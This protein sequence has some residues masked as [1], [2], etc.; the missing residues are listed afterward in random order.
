MP[1]RVLCLL[2]CVGPLSL[3]YPCVRTAHVPGMKHLSPGCCLF[4]W[5]SHSC[6]FCFLHR[7]TS[8]SPSPSHFVFSHQPLSLTRCH[9]LL[10]FIFLFLHPP[11]PSASNS[12]FFCLLNM[13]GIVTCTYTEKKPEIFFLLETNKKDVLSFN[14]FDAS[15]TFSFK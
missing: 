9:L 12:W 11:A 4:L 1:A 7:N 2:H 13:Q 3:C 10:L 8:P 5:A 6:L 14:I 15:C